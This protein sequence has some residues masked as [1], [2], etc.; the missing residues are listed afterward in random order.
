MIKIVL[1][2]CILISVIWTALLSDCSET[3]Q[4]VDYS[5]CYLSEPDSLLKVKDV[6]FKVVGMDS[7]TV[8][9]VQEALDETPGVILNFACYADTIV[10]VEYDTTKVCKKE[11]ISVIGTTGFIAKEKEW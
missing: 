8:Y 4:N 10:F 9:N 2:I 7:I 1:I 5:V 11:L 6:V 3:G